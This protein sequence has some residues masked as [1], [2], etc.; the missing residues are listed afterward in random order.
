MWAAADLAAIRWT[1]SVSDE[2]D[3]E[4]WVSLGCWVVVN[5]FFFL[6]FSALSL[7]FRFVS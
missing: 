2:L 7:D 4:G 1:V 6:F 3:F 5:S